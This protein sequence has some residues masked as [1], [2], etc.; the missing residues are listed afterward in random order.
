MQQTDKIPASYAAKAQQMVEAL[1]QMDQIVVA[2]HV[3]PDGDAAGSVAAV[4]HILRAMGK[5]FILYANPGLPRYLDFF[6]MPAV[7][8]T[9]LAHPPFTPK[10]AVLLDCGEPDRL[11]A[12]LAALLPQLDCVNIDHHLGGNGMGSRANWVVTEAAATAQLVAYMAMAA[13]LPLTGDLSL[14]VALGL[15]TDTGGFCHGN[16]SADVLALAAH[17]VEN[18]CRLAWL[19]EQ[20]DNSW[21]LGRWRL[22]G[23][24]M[25]NSRIEQEGQVG[26]CQVGLEDLRRC[27]A[28]KEDMEGF[29][30]HLRRL[31]DVKIAALLREDSPQ[32]CKFSLRSYGNIDV[33]SIA[34]AMDGGGHFNAAG[35]T[36]RMPLKEAGQVLLR[37]IGLFLTSQNAEAK[38]QAR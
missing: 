26:F 8:H 31:R 30:E 23:L 27:Q 10:C 24:L 17:L 14:A 15:I 36:L 12:E 18:G 4:G 11:G 9:T 28:L 6:P 16:T 33:R 21:S 32:L 25:E 37:H 34:A 29:V 2:G 22:W 5:E 19:R 35:G 13:N 20:L 38:K 1:K 3:H 7:V